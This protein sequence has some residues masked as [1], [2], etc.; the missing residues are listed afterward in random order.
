MKY[1]LDTN[2]WVD[3]LTGRY[4]T[5][6]A[7]IQE[8]SPEDLC[9]SSV[10]MAELR[11]GAEKSQ[12]KRPNHRLLD[13]LGRETRCVDFDLDAAAPPLAL[14]SCARPATE[15][16]CNTIASASPNRHGQ[17]TPTIPQ[18]SSRTALRRPRPT[19]EGPSQTPPSSVNLPLYHNIWYH[20][21]WVS[22]SLQFGSPVIRIGSSDNDAVRDRSDLDS[23]LGESVEE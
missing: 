20:N 12:R 16:R 21:N 18:H 3:Y 6:V 13:T 5:V 9:L 1:L 10:V 23:L 22:P 8:S 17:G 11:Y 15:A 14:R 7:R 19:T 2:V 4:P